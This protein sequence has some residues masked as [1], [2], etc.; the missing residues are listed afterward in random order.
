LAWFNYDYW[1]TAR[2]SHTE[3]R[4][5]PPELTPAYVKTLVRSLNAG[6]RYADFLYTQL[7]DSRTGRWRLLAH[8]R[9]NRARMR[10]EAV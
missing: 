3:A 9:I 1:L 5:L 10:A 6:G 7:V 4:T 8:T 2:V